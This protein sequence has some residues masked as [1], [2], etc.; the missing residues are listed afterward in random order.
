MTTGKWNY[1]VD[2]Q[3]DDV[4]CWI[5]ENWFKRSA[6]NASIHSNLQ[7]SVTLLDNAQV[8]QQ[9]ILISSSHRRKRYAVPPDLKKCAQNSNFVKPRVYDS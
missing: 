9:E 8:Y 6:T 4:T 7:Q 3:H 2:I 5:V 1:I